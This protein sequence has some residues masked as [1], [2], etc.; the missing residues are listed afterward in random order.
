MLLTMISRLRET[1]WSLYVRPWV[2]SSPSSLVEDLT[3][4]SVEGGQLRRKREAG[5]DGKGSEIN[6]QFIF[7][8][9]DPTEQFKVELLCLA[10][11]FDLTSVLKNHKVDRMSSTTRTS[12]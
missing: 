8:I 5:S 7:T 11:K 1:G 4:R 6:L 9:G 2:E 3:K 10:E 12:S